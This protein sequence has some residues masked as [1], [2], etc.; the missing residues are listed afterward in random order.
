MSYRILLPSGN[1]LS[2]S[3]VGIYSPS[4]PHIL[5]NL[6]VTAL[7]TADIET[8]FT[9]ASLTIVRVQ[10]KCEGTR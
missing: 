7:R 5:E 3:V 1:V 2:C 10:L 9:T 8:G 6:I 4:Q